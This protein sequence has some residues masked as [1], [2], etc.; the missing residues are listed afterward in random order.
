MTTNRLQQYIVDDSTWL[1][2]SE[3][4][5]DKQIM[6]PYEFAINELN[7]NNRSKRKANG[8][9]KRIMEEKFEGMLVS[10]E[11]IEGSS[12]KSS[13]RNNSFQE[14]IY[15][16]KG[17]LAH[18]R[19]QIDTLCGYNGLSS[20]AEGGAAEMSENS[21]KLIEIRER[22]IKVETLSE[23]MNSKLDTNSS[24]L[25]KIELM[26]QKLPQ[27]DR[28]KVVVTEEIRAAKVAS[29][30][31]VAGIFASLSKDL[32]NKDYVGNAVSKST[33]KIIYWLIG[34]ILATAAAT[35]AIMQ[36]FVK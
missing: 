33:L 9:I 1:N 35:G 8:I 34:T 19:K 28:M 22:L 2:R 12:F 24:K 11:I 20:W 17:E 15:Y 3:R 23:H 21:E 30:D 4:N 27:E 14:D 18:I 5:P 29:E 32:P 7:K 36:I 31:Y 16:I 13:M 26:L 25:D 6:D 10:D